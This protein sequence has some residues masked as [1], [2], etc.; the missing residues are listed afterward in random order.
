MRINKTLFYKAYRERFGPISKEKTVDSINAILDAFSAAKITIR[1]M[2]KLAYA[3]ATVRHEVGPNMLPI[4]ENLNYSAQR[5]CQVW[6][7]RFPTISHAAPYANN[8][9]A[10]GNKVYGGRLGNGVFDGFKFRGRGIGAQITGYDS[11]KKYGDLLGIDM[12]TN[13]DLAMNLEVGAKILVLGFTDYPFTGY[14]LSNSINN[15]KVDY[16][17]ARRTVNA[18]MGRVGESI[19]NDAKKFYE[20]LAFSNVM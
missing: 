5:M 17:N 2:E 10:L 13:P 18:D 8:P 7:S 14:K 11:Y 12:V 19:A 3:L 6:P 1:P 4:V 20:I 9:E 15:T 16:M